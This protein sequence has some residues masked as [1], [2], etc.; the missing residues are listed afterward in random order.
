MSR[1]IIQ[2]RLYDVSD[3]VE[4]IRHHTLKSSAD[5]FEAEGELFISKGAPGTDE[6]RLVLINRSNVNL[7][8]T[9]EAVHKRI[10]L[11]ARTLINE[12]INEWRGVVVLWASSI[13]VAVIN[14]DT[15]G[16]LFFVDRDD[17]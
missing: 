15:N 7:V 9:R 14:A 12:L 5:I 3:I 11:A 10:Y 16:A 6:G 17:I 2:I 1:K 8:V 4:S 13:N